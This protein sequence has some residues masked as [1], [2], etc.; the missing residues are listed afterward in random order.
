M[1]KNTLENLT[2]EDIAIKTNISVSYMK[3]LFKTYAGISPK[4]YYNLL[5]VQ[6]ATEL[7]KNG[8][9]VTEVALAMNFS[10]ASYFSAFF[11]RETG[12]PPF[13]ALG[14]H[15]TQNNTLSFCVRSNFA[16][17]SRQSARR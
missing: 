9:S 7:L 14:G 3:S 1:S 17:P 2:L 12:I 5:R 11:K 15:F 8:N 13:L 4:S 16:T 6:T 10:S